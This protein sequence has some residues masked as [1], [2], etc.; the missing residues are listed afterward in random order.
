MLGPA[1]DP[2]SHPEANTA[3]ILSV[4]L[5]ELPEAYRFPDVKENVYN[6]VCNYNFQGELIT[7][8][9]ESLGCR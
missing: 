1:P 8:F 2:G 4:E 3:S 9:V 6:T 7:L 5:P